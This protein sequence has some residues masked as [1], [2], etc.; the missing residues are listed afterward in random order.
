MKSLSQFRFRQASVIK[1]RGMV[2]FLALLAIVIMS[3]AAVA[4][5]RSVD[6]GTLI[7]GNLAFKRAANSSG[8]GGTERAITWL[9]ATQ[10]ANNAKNAVNDTTHTFNITNTAVGYYSN[11]DPALDLYASSTW[12]AAPTVPS[13]GTGNTVQYIMQRMCRT[14]N[15][16]VKDADCLFSG[17]LEDTN[18]QAIP[19]P[20]QICEGPGCPAAGQTPQIRITVRTTGPKNTISYLQAF[21]Y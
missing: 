8:D 16:A 5:I 12:T 20:Q 11:L 9:T 2:L 3:L 17:P 10:T 1:Q 13:D 15:V 18:G 21:V 7:A 6:T 19:I 14:A 4:L